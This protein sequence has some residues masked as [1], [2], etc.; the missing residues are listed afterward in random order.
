MVSVAVWVTPPEMPVIVAV[1]AVCKACVVMAKVAEVCPL[2]TVTIAG[3]VAVVLL[4]DRETMS[5][6]AGAGFVRMTVPVAVAPPITEV[7]FSATLER[8]IVFVWVPM[9]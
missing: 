2:G 8:G 3:T 4:L 9:A 5:P 6:P 1:V 7:G